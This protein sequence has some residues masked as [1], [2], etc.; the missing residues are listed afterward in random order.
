[1]IPKYVLY[2]DYTGSKFEYLPLVAKNPFE[3]VA[4]AEQI[5]RTLQKNDCVYLVRLME[6]SGKIESRDISDWRRQKYVAK[7]C[8]RSEKCGWHEN[9]E[10]HSENPHEVYRYY[11]CGTIVRMFYSSTGQGEGWS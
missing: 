11:K 9:N 4:E 6:K 3:A 5:Y 8:K 2:V 1:M 7:L 10:L